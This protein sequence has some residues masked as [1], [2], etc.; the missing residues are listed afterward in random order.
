MFNNLGNLIK[1]KFFAKGRNLASFDE[2]YVVMP[3]L[4]RNCSI[5]GVVDAGASDG[6]RSR[7][8]LRLFPS[9]TAYAFEPNPMY[10]D[11]LKK[12]ADSEKRFCPQFSALSDSNGLLELNITNSP[13]NTSL[14]RPSSHLQELAT[15][16]AVVE[17]TESVEVVALDD[18]AR[19][20]GDP[21][22]ELI[23]FDIQGNELKALKG[24]DRTLSGSELLIHTE[25][26]FQPLYDEGALFGQIDLLLREYGFELYDLYRPKYGPNG[27][28]L[29]ANAIFI[30]TKRIEKARG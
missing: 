2:P 25:V 26:C 14:L 1:K 18:W 9:A 21:S 10:A 27:F 17:K 22:I 11:D 8:F 20:N 23:K 28:L 24:T 30:H 5:N 13:G 7:R 16:G 19:E 3:E 4:L 12:Y 15:K 6:R 29:W